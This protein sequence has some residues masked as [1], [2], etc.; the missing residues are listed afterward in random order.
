M[1][2]DDRLTTALSDTN[3]ATMPFTW[4]DAIPLI[5]LTLLDAH[6][7]LDEIHALANKAR[8][9]RVAAI[10]ILPEHLS[11]VSPEIYIKRAAVVNFPTGTQPQ[12]KVLNTIEQTATTMRVDE[13]DYV[14]PYQAYLS[15]DQTQALAYC[16]EVYQLC[17]KHDLLFK[18]I[19]ETGALPSIEII[20][21]MSTAILQSGCD[22]LK[23]S[24]G[25]IATGATIPAVFSMLAAIVDS[26]IRCG[27]KVSGG[28]KTTEQALSYLRLAQHMLPYKL[29]RNCMRLG[30]SSLL[31]ELLKIGV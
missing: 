17:K 10:C 7:T 20:Y 6:A 2:L 3:A 5:D 8:Q 25:K 9:N 29:D 26:N 14:F 24:T 15:G 4:Q 12:Q 30:A 31:D 22:F 28:I 11:Y 13:I 23:T 18:V 1:N 27:I 21:E 19:L 16:Q